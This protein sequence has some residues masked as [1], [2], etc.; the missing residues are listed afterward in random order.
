[1][2]EESKHFSMGP[3]MT[4]IGMMESSKK[5][6]AH[7][8]MEN[9]MKGNGSKE[10]LMELE[11]W[12]DGRKY[13]GQW[14]MGKPTGKGK[15]VYPDGRAKEGYWENGAFIEG[16]KSIQPNIIIAN[17]NPITEEEKP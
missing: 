8:P 7:I 2:A 16:S 15:K 13:D 17:P 3:H 12:P 4:V 6:C 9:F 11:S 5:G 10:N 1:M 14:D